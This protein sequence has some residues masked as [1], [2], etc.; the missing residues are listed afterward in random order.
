VPLGSP[1]T[2]PTSKIFSQLC[3]YQWATG[4]PP[5]ISDLRTFDVHGRRP[6]DWLQPIAGSAKSLNVFIASRQ[7]IPEK[8]ILWPVSVS[9]ELNL[10]SF[11]CF[12]LQQTR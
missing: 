10:Q 5:L 11:A 8:K 4:V 3:L 12:F 1:A 7:S 6:R 9:S 2:R